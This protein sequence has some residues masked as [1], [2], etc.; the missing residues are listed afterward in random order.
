MGQL[1]NIS[2]RKYRDFLA[3]QGL[4]F[5]HYNGG[6]EIWVKEGLL[7]PVTFQTHID[8]V[9]EFIIKNGLRNIGVARQVLID[10]LSK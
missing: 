6:H 8:P 1:S 9:P 2:P 7:R 5:S 4:H 3:S 10:F